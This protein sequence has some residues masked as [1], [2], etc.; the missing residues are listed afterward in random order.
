MKLNQL[1]D[2][3]AVAER[4]SLRAAARHLGVAQ[5]GL[6]RSLRQLEHELG[7]PLFER[8]AKGMGVTPAGE[9]FLR[10]AR[11][12][13]GELRRAREE[14]DQARGLTHGFVSVCLSTTAQVALLT[15]ALRPFR[16]RYPQVHLDIVDGLYP[17]IEPA[18]KDGTLDCYI[19]PVPARVSAD[20][21]SEKLFDLTRVILGRKGHPLAG[22]R[23]LRELVGAEWVTTSITYKAEEELGPLF[24]HYGLPAPRLVIQAHSA[25]TFL[26]SV[27]YSDV[28]A[29]L[30]AQWLEFPLTRNALQKIEVREPLP[31]PPI[32]IVRRA[33][34]P[35][36]PAAEYFCDLVRRASV[37]MAANNAPARANHASTARPSRPPSGARP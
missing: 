17:G 16:T 7:V 31:G 22:A 27:A 5:A 32:C 10:R 36:T 28:V 15:S 21:V 19:G 34:L 35:L 14:I 25:L 1:R 18:L 26:V 4:G 23:S 13:R 3:L 8:R 29:M 12:A 20:F 33:D 37:Q 30:P 6:T 9:I 24:E 11:A 2:V